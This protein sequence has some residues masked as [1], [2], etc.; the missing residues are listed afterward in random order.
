MVFLLHSCGVFI[1][2]GSKAYIVPQVKA[3]LDDELHA[4]LKHYRDAQGNRRLDETVEQLIAI[5]INQYEQENERLPTEYEGDHPK[6]D[7]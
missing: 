5:Q 1:V 6:W 2:I 3:H 7:R 4:K